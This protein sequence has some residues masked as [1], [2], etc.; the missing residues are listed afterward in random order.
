MVG[1]AFVPPQFQSVGNEVGGITRMT[2]NQKRL[3]NRLLASRLF[4]N[5]QRNENGAGPQVMVIRFDRNGS[6]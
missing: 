2:K 6:P 4:E 5:S 1:L 3:I